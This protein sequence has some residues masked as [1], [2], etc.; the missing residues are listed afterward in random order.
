MGRRIVK[1]SLV[2]V[3]VVVALGAGAFWW[4]FV[5]DDAPAEARLVEREVAQD[6]TGGVEGAWSVQS[7][8]D[9]FAGYRI[10]ERT[11]VGVDNTAVARTKGVEGSMVVE[12]ERITAVAVTADLAGL[13]SQ[14]SQ[15]PGVGNRDVAM[16]TAGLETDEF[17]TATFTLTEPIDLGPSPQAGQE[18]TA[19][20]RGELVLHGVTR[21]VTV[22]ISARWNGEVIDLTA[23]AEVALA[24]F[25]IEQ[26]ASQ[27]VTVADTG[28]I[29]LQLTFVPTP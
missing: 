11:V 17:P 16:R 13:V 24:D 10:Q 20:A 22:A 14:D 21:E 12:G 3:L 2:V 18:L 4:A 9:V 5:R 8:P 28:T 1:V 27:V 26:P 19:S 6:T 25:G 23:S 7:G 15:V 29:E